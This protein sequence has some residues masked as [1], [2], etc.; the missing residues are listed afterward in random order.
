MSRAILLKFVFLMIILLI[1]TIISYPILTYASNQASS[2]GDLDTLFGTN[3]IITTTLASRGTDLALDSKGRILVVGDNTSVLRFTDNGTLD[4][5]FGITGVITS[6]IT[7]ND[8]VVQS[9]QKIVMAGYYTNDK[10]QKSFAL[11]R[12]LEDGA[13]DLTFGNNGVVTTTINQTSTGTSLILQTDGKLVVG[14]STKPASHLTGFALARYNND[15]SLD[16]T[17]GSNGIITDLPSTHIGGIAALAQQSDGKLVAAGT[18]DQNFTLARYTISG[19]IDT[20]FGSTGVITTSCGSNCFGIVT[21]LEIDTNGKISVSGWFGV[22]GILNGEGLRYNPDGSFDQYLTD[23]GRNE[24]YYRAITL[25]DE[26]RLY[27]TGSWL[28]SGATPYYYFARFID[29]VY[30]SSFEQVL[31]LYV[32]IWGMTGQ[33]LLIQSDKKIV[34]TG[35][36]N[37]TLFLARYL[38]EAEVKAFEFKV[39]IPT[40]IQNK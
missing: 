27:G 36:K 5:T 4:T 37:R 28:S 23:L 20:T 11:T 32:P 34:T 8:I 39:Y 13:L 9:D 29:G 24:L 10:G 38:G 7:M 35:T 19:A 3:G 22:N 2:P 16:T 6:A 26:D 18:H 25:D 31:G 33:D 1:F 30:D 17:F 15:G 12:L 14:G 21:D 40:I